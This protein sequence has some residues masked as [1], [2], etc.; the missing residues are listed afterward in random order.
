MNAVGKKGT[1]GESVRCVVSVS[2]LTEGWDV[3]TVTHILGLRAFGTQLL[4]EQGGR[5]SLRR[6]SYSLDETGKFRTE[7]A[8]I[9]GIPFA[10]AA[11]PVI[12]KPVPPPQLLH[13]FAEK[14]EAAPGLLG[15]GFLASSSSCTDSPVL[16]A[17]S[18]AL[19]HE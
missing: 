19:G 11:N 14:D 4:C 2:M 10:F 7:Y 12:A 3:N 18:G 17:P 15:Y 6:L 13:V 1:L 8:D 16:M 9:L 5:R